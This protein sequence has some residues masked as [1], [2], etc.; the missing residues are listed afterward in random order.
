MSNEVNLFSDDVE[1]IKIVS[2]LYGANLSEK[3]K[4]FKADK[5]VKLILETFETEDNYTNDDYV[6]FLRKMTRKIAEDERLKKVRVPGD[7]LK[8]TEIG[9]ESDVD[10]L[11]KEIVEENLVEEIFLN[12][13]F[14]L[15]NF[16]FNE[17]E[18]K[19]L[20]LLIRISILDEYNTLVK[21]AIGATMIEIAK[22]LEEVHATNAA[23]SMRKTFHIAS[24]YPSF[25]E[26]ISSKMYDFI[27]NDLDYVLNEHIEIPFYIVYL[28][29]LKL[30]HKILSSFSSNFSTLNNLSDSLFDD[31]LQDLL[32]NE[33]IILENGIKCVL[34]T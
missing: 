26:Y 24:K 23:N 3:N 6:Q 30:Y 19:D 15:Q 4:S 34:G 20:F 25:N 22:A 27:A 17:K 1:F 10:N 16:N 18:I 9:N 32:Y 12:I 21:V 28:F 7:F 31:I 29:W 8:N 2:I 14:E 33:L 5:I 11:L 13:A